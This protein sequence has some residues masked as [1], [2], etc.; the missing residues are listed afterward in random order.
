MGSADT[1][2][3]ARTRPIANL[4]RWHL[5]RLV[6]VTL[7]L[8]LPGLST[9]VLA[10]MQADYYQQT[11]AP[12][13]D[14]ASRVRDDLSDSLAAYHEYLTSGDTGR[15]DA[16]RQ[17]RAGYFTVLDAQGRESALSAERV[18]TL[19]TAGTDW[20]AA[21]DRVIA[22]VAAE[23]P[24]DARPA[25]AAYA[26]A[27]DASRAA[28]GDALRV[29]DDWAALHDRT[30]T[31]GILLT[32][33][34][35]LLAAVAAWRLL[36]SSQS[37][38]AAPLLRLAAVVRAF[39]AGDWSVRAPTDRGSTEVVAVASALNRLAHSETAIRAEQ[40][41]SLHMWGTTSAV[42]TEL[43]IAP[44]QPGHWSP[45]C[46]ILG[47]ALGVDRVVLNTW[48]DGHFAPLGS[49]SSS[50]TD[51]DHYLLPAISGRVAERVLR[52]PLVAGT[53]TEID[54]R[55]PTQLAA[56]MHHEGGRSWLLHP[57]RVADGVVGALSIWSRAERHWAPAELVAI[58]RCAF[59][60]AQTV[61]DARQLARLQD[62]EQEKT[63]FLAT[64]SHELRT[65]LTSI[66][67]YVELLADGEF[68]D[69]DPDQAHAL[70]VVERNVRRLRSLVDDLLILSGLDSGRAITTPELIPV[71]A[72]VRDALAQ[73]R[74]ED[75]TGVQI[76]YPGVNDGLSRGT[77]GDLPRGDDAT[78]RP[79]TSGVA[80]ITGVHD[81]LVRAL[82]CVLG[83]ALKFS[84]PGGTVHLAVTVDADSVLLICRDEGI[85]IPAAEVD[86]VFARFY[87]ATNAAREEVQG[88]GLGLAI[89]K[90][91]VE[92]HG[93]Q[94]L[95]ESTE[96]VGTTVTMRLPLAAVGVPVPS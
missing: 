93:G 4:V 42:V 95:V 57:L 7:L 96:G 3:G 17:A 94:V 66:S 87:R 30:L 12:A 50:G 32:V 40:D 36:R 55:F 38:I 2:A 53:A 78:G 86:K 64:T 47:T 81:Q 89:T 84:L 54:E 69:I 33:T 18:A 90:I 65:P 11:V 25:N 71:D 9:A 14:T 13:R 48:E 52:Q 24:A 83:N 5:T 8:A 56:L 35:A 41:L 80:A 72:V 37:A 27:V 39:D 73:V 59:A 19:R 46:T 61:A 79:T 76:D 10:R 77:G 28:M 6:S 58:E 82:R 16:Y 75:R 20:F 23:R 51:A 63:A 92:G 45:A 74:A 31:V 60:A 21:A 15:I 91:V 44:G 70:S 68:G 67:G 43:A 26:R 29:R 22:D 34:S 62:L 85:G 88:T 49:W 1:T